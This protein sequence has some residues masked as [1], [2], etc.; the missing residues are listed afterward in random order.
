MT[1]CQNWDNIIVTRVQ[2]T[3]R[4]VQELS[5][6]F[7]TKNKSVLTPTDDGFALKGKVIVRWLISSDFMTF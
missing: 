2:L 5:R 4:A 6:K 1:M 7:I 3:I